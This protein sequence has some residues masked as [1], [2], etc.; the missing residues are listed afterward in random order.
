MLD[1]TSVNG[2]RWQS[3][4]LQRMH[5]GQAPALHIMLGCLV[6]MS[7]LYL[8]SVDSRTS[9]CLLKVVFST[10]KG[11]A[12]V[13]L[14][15]LAACLVVPAIIYM[16]W[17]LHVPNMEQSW[18]CQEQSVV[19]SYILLHG[20]VFLPSNLCFSLPNCH[21][22]STQPDIS[23]LSMLI[24]TTI[25]D[26]GTMSYTRPMQRSAL[27]KNWRLKDETQLA[28]LGAEAD[29]RQWGRGPSSELGGPGRPTNMNSLRE[30][31]ARTTL[32]IKEGRRLRVE[33]LPYTAR[34]EQV[35]DLFRSKGYQV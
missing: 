5:L 3:E 14:C 25:I 7:L 11:P 9:I 27:S 31:G 1:S 35:K 15:K 16:L 10:V 12:G 23:I 21:H 4:E 18:G 2:C 32:A 26:F 22:I 29:H 17:Q 33:N 6:S 8:L 30:E 34:K 13:S 28:V 19:L 24:L 20:Q